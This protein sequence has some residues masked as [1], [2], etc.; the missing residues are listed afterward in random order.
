MSSKLTPDF[1]LSDSL[2]LYDQHLLPVSRMSQKMDRSFDICFESSSSKNERFFDSSSFETSQGFSSREVTV[3]ETKLQ[4]D[5]LENS[6]DGIH[7]TTSQSGRILDRSPDRRGRDRSLDKSS[8]NHSFEATEGL[9]V[10]S[11]RTLERRSDRNSS[12]VIGRAASSIDRRGDFLSVE[13]EIIRSEER[14]LGSDTVNKNQTSQKSNVISSQTHSSLSSSTMRD[15]LNKSHEQPQ[16]ESPVTLDV[17]HITNRIISLTFPSDGH[18]TS[19][20]FNL[21]EAMRLLR[22]KHGDHFLIVN[23]S[24]KHPELAKA[25]PQVKEF[26]WPD[27]LAPPLE[28]LCL[29]CKAI[30]T[31]LSSDIRH[32][33]VLH[34]KGGRSRLAS[35]VAAYMHYNNICASAGQAVD[36]LTM[37]K[38]YDDKLVGLPLPSQ[39]RYVAYFSGLLSG[40]IKIN[41]QPLYLHHILIHGVPDFDG[42]GGCCPFI[43]V[44]QSMQPIFTSGVY[45]VTDNMQKV[46]ISIT[47][48][49]PLR[50]DILVKCYHKS[51]RSGQKEVI[52][53]C[54]FHTCAITGNQVVYSKQELDDAALDPRFPD[55]GKVQFV[56]GSSSDV[57]V[58]VTGFKSDVTVPIVDSEESMV[59]TDSYEE[60][61]KV[62]GLA[63]DVPISVFDFNKNRILSP[64]A[65][66]G[67]THIPQYT[68]SVDHHKAPDGSLY[69]KVTKRELPHPSS[70]A[71]S[72]S[73]HF[74]N[75]SIAS[76]WDT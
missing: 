26:G 1:D 33:V 67:S 3:I 70:A 56:F 59:R 44:Y 45:N 54:Q 11:G 65:P 57:L 9:S 49:I 34:C 55:S 18:D 61:N 7:L 51:A 62:S 15:I 10:R 42:R 29:I 40:A 4:Q 14:S 27:H 41:S 37:K 6:S 58:S 19:Y 13:P 53:Q 22:S 17:V 46:C 69:A 39:Q 50:G 2:E 74:T 31:W 71:N 5:G 36:S 38:Y 35:V 16:T 48:G 20:I 75:G 8:L 25:H 23:L 28:R 63:A 12:E 24:E 60:F 76:S 47:P 64:H 52:W 21:N 30:D 43:K 32:I 72:G 73:I 66:G 68:G